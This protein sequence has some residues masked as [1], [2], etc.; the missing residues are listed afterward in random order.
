MD[1]KLG[2][3]EV[4]IFALGMAA[5]GMVREMYQRFDEKGAETFNA[6]TSATH[7]AGGPYQTNHSQGK[8]PRNKT[9]FILP[10]NSIGVYDIRYGR[11]ANEYG[12]TW[13]QP[14]AWI[15]KDGTAQYFS[16]VAL[17]KKSIEDKGNYWIDKASGKVSPNARTPAERKSAKA[18][19]K[20]WRK[21]YVRKWW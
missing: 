14:Y 15:P 16:T 18:K 4:C 5:G 6:P 13:N 21:K 17:A 1:D 8:P 10:G 7:L 20:R 2:V 12:S 9:K 3:R 11:L 19:F